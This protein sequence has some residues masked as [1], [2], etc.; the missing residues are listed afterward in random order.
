MSG[1]KFPWLIDP[2][3]MARAGR[4]LEGELEL[5]A[6]PRLGEALCD[7]PAKARIRMQFGRDDAGYSHVN[8]TAAA[9]LSLRCQRCLECMDWPVEVSFSLGIV[10][11]EEQAALLPEIY[12]PLIAGPKPVAIADIIE[13]ELI[14]AL[15]IVPMHESTACRLPDSSANR[16]EQPQQDN[17]KNPFRMLEQLKTKK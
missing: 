14:L 8:G 4:T 10:T 9:D 6:M 16:S 2:L 15:P 1:R 12:E 17:E 7:T 13:D 11:G 5:S 3:E